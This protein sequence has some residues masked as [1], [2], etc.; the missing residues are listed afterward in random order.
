MKSQ[1]SC[2][3]LCVISFE[4]L[5]ARLCSSSIVATSRKQV[6]NRLYF[7]VFNPVL[8]PQFSGHLNESCYTGNVSEQPYL[9][10]RDRVDVRSPSKTWWWGDPTG[11]QRIYLSQPVLSSVYDSSRMISN[12]HLCALTIEIYCMFLFILVYLQYEYV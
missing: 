2:I 5:Y 1:A 6:T 10:R 7:V 9:Y 3:P 12:V 11:A 8:I 4:S